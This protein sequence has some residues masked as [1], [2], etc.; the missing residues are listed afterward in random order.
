MLVPYMT[1]QFIN[2]LE[3]KYYN[4]DIDYHGGYFKA[5]FESK[6][7]EYWMD[8]TIKNN[9]ITVTSFTSANYIMPNFAISVVLK[10]ENGQLKVDEL[11]ISRLPE[12]NGKDLT[13]SQTKDLLAYV[14]DYK[15]IQ[16]EETINKYSVYTNRVEKMYCYTVQEPTQANKITVFVSS[17][18]GSIQPPID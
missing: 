1:Q 12:P 6:E 9:Q 15:H 2:N 11:N 10:Q 16:Y 7:F 17:Y 14:H 3:W 13:K 4:E 8:Y 18:D 5:F